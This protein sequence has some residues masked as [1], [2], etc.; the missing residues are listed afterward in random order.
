MI[1]PE[2]EV[3]SIDESNKEHVEGRF[4]IEWDAVKYA[5]QIANTYGPT[6]FQD[7]EFPD[8]IVKITIRP[9]WILNIKV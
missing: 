5:N 9:V 7:I 4:T 6:K 2:F 8:R 1:S 3:L